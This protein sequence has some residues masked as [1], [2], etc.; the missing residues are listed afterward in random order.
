MAAA[1]EEVPLLPGTGEHGALSASPPYGGCCILGAAGCAALLAL[2]AVGAVYEARSTTMR[3]PSQRFEL[4][5]VG[6]NDTECVGADLWM[7][8]RACHL[9]QC[10]ERCAAEPRCDAWSWNPTTDGS[11]WLKERC[12]APQSHIGVVSGWGAKPPGAVW[13]RLPAAPPAAIPYAG[14]RRS[15]AT[16]DGFKVG[17]SLGG[18]MVMETSWMFDQFWS[19]SENDWTRYMRWYGGDDYA[20]RAM[21]NHWE[22]F[23]PTEAVDAAADLGTNMVRIPVGYWITEPPVGGSSEREFGFNHEGFATGGITY[24]ERMLAK[25]KQRGMTALIDLHSL[26]GGQSVCQTHAGMMVAQPNFWRGTSPGPGEQM[27][28]CNN[29]WGAGPYTSSREPGTPWMKVGIRAAVWLARW[30]TQL[31]KDP[32]TAGVVTDYE[33]VNEPAV[34]TCGY[35]SVIQAYHDAV[36]P[37]VQRIFMAAGLGVRI[38]I[39]AHLTIDYRM[40]EWIA[41]RIRDGA[42]DG[43]SILVDYHNYYNWEGPMGWEGL[44]ERICRTTQTSCEWGQFI[45]SGLQTAIGEWSVGTNMADSKYWNLNDTNC[46]RELATLYANQISM[47]KSIP[48]TVGMFYYSLRMGSGWDPRPSSEFPNGRQVNGTAW[49]TSI[50]SYASRHWNLG[51]LKRLG[52]VRPFASYEIAGLCDC[53]GCQRP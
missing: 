34:D 25:L 50:P 47:Y 46:R 2:V 1:D 36:V 16:Q 18:W 26:P 40:G 20:S 32:A 41:G 35:E 9:E 23:I 53:V 39:N 12:V 4:F 42:Y 22:H 24:V 33:L 11:C 7:G 17:V 38:S 27:Q 45:A 29:F 43:T 48:G 15:A 37:Q 13:P 6:R 44:R 5:S 30:I 52:I 28:S 49:D 31:E 51:E 14:S 8:G 3:I 21:R 19:P 10:S